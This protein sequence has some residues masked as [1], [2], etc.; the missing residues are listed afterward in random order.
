[1]KQFLCG[2]FTAIGLLCVI[3]PGPITLGLPYVLCGAMTV[4]GIVYGVS[5][6]RCREAWTNRAPELANALVLPVVGFLC[7]LHG[8]DS[9]GPLG[10]TWAN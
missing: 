7:I 4:A 8:A 10:T 2:L 6:F 5:Y 3:F 1:M 9:I